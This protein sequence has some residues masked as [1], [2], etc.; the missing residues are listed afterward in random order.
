M[1]Y[2]TNCSQCGFLYE[3]GSDK[4]ASD[5]GR[6]CWKCWEAMCELHDAGEEFLDAMGERVDIDGRLI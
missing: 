2:T 4:Q 6:L 5:P 1:S 3:V